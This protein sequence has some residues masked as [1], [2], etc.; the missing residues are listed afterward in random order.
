MRE[1]TPG[2]WAPSRMVVES[3]VHDDG[4][5]QLDRRTES[6]VVVRAAEA[7]RRRGFAFEPPYGVDV[8]DRRLGYSYHNDPWWPE[9]GELLRERFDWPKSDLSPLGSL[10]SP[11]RFE[12]QAAP[13][14]SAAAWINSKPLEIAKLKGKVVLLEFWGT[15]CPP[16]RRDDPGDEDAVRNVST[17]GPRDHFDSHADRGCQRRPAVRPQVSDGLSN[18]C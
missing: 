5:E 10:G 12:G 2:I 16:C 1:V 8:T 15:W 4:A 18:R 9:A 17:R 3:G 14:I 11:A 7:L 6:R 13:P